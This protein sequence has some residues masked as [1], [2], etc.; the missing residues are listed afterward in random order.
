MAVKMVQGPA[1]HARPS[2]FKARVHQRS[3]CGWYPLYS[4]QTCSETFRHRGLCR[5]LHER[6]AEPR[7]RCAQRRDLPVLGPPLIFCSAE[8]SEG[9]PMRE[10]VIDDAGNLVGRS[11]DNSRKQSGPHMSIIVAPPKST[12]VAPQKS[13]SMSPL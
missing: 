1:R 9:S 13:T 3:S 11:H 2:L 5:R 10:Q 4:L 12:Q 6:E 8:V 7:G